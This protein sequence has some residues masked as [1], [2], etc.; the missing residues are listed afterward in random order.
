MEIHKKL[1]H[2]N[3]ACASK[4]FLKKIKEILNGLERKVSKCRSPI[5]EP[6]R[7]EKEHIRNRLLKAGLL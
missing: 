2:I 4:P 5:L 7:K 1:F 3:K 6:D